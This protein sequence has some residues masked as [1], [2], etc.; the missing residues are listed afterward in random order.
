MRVCADGARQSPSR[1]RPAPA[2]ISTGG[3]GRSNNLPSP[4]WKEATSGPQPEREEAAAVSREAGRAEGSGRAGGS[5]LLPAPRPRYRW[6]GAAG[7]SEEGRTEMAAATWELDEEEGQG[8]PSG[9]PALGG[10]GGDGGG[11]RLSRDAPPAPKGR[12]SL[13][14]GLSLREE[15]PSFHGRRLP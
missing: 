6:S 11:G 14:L 1:P 3:G 7:G 8:F 13:R 5:R 12:A 10:G 9:P 15:L 2:S 4:C